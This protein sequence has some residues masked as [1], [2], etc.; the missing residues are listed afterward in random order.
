MGNLLAG[1]VISSIAVMLIRKVVNNRT[2]KITNTRRTNHL[3]IQIRHH[4]FPPTPR[5]PNSENRFPSQPRALPEVLLAMLG[6][7]IALCPRNL[8]RLSQPR[9][10]RI[11]SPN[12]S[13]KHL[14]LLIPSTK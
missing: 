1:A 10:K 2:D 12:S 13:S 8:L 9:L 7:P 6:Q 3:I 14:D 4:N 5:F 11:A